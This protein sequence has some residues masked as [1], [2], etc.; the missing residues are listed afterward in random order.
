MAIKHY[1][2]ASGCEKDASPVET[3]QGIHEGRG[4]VDLHLG[5]GGPHREAEPLHPSL[6]DDT[7]GQ[8]QK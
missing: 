4:H 7:N 3:G 6:V 8:K 5:P 1:Q 2:L